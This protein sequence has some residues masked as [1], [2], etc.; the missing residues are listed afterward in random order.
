MLQKDEISTNRPC[1]SDVFLKWFE[2][3]KVIHYEKSIFF[4]EVMEMVAVDKVMDFPKSVVVSHKEYFLV[5][6]SKTFLPTLLHF[7]CG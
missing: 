3:R 7:L 4:S 1:V 6:V 2:E 5:V